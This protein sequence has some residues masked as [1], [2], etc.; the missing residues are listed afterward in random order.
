MKMMCN[1]K[2]NYLKIYTGCMFSGKSTCL[3]N[4]ISKF[5]ILSKNILVLNHCLDSK[6]TNDINCIMSHDKKQFKAFM[7]NKLEDITIDQ[8]I[9]EIYKNS[10]IVIIDESQFFPDLYRFVETQLKIKHLH[11]KIFIVSGL[12]GDSSLQ[13]IG[14][15]LKLIPLADEVIKLNAYCL[16]CKDGTIASFSKRRINCDNSQIL[17]GNS[18][19][20]IPVCRFHY[21]NCNENN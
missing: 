9:F 6:R 16:K 18:D 1:L 10:D 20:Y 14:D 21:Y 19:I 4:E 7:L 13:P 3:L 15:I 11:N 8:S 5:K 12:S 17:I 2:H